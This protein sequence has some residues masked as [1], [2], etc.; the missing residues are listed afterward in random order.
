M[1]GAITLTRERET[2]GGGIVIPSEAAKRRSRGIAILPK[3]GPFPLSG[4]LRFLDSAPSA[5]RSE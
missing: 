4:R 2:H 5:L 3:E 1:P